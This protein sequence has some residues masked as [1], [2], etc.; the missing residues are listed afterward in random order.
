MKALPRFDTAGLRAS[1]IV[2]DIDSIA[3]AVYAPFGN[4]PTH[5]HYPGTKQRPV[6]KHPLVKSLLKVAQLGIHVHAL[7]DLVDDDSYVVEIDA[8]RPAPIVVSAWKQDM[9]SPY[10]LAGFLR[11]VRDRRPCSSL[12][13]ALEG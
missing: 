8:G 7:I 13:L 6:L 10:A 3:L 12:V 5:S 11:H 1:D 2:R 4:D 9:A